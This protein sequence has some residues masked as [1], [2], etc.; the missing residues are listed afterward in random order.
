MGQTFAIKQAAYLYLYLKL[1]V[2][3]DSSTNITQILVCKTKLSQII[4]SVKETL[5]AIVKQWS[6]YNVKMRIINLFKIGASR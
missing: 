6:F 2:F 5:F 4:N 1:S 3:D